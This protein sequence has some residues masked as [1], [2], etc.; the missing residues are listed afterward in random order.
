MPSP[1]FNTVIQGMMSYTA[2]R[3]DT[4]TLTGSGN[5]GLYNIF[6]DSLTTVSTRTPLYRTLKSWQLPDQ[7]YDKYRNTLSDPKFTFVAYSRAPGS[8]YQTKWTITSNVAYSGGRLTHDLASSADDPAQRAISKLIEEMSVTRSNISVGAAELGKTA[9]MVAKSAT[10]IFKAVKALKNARFG[11]FAGV[12]GLTTT[13]SQSRRFYTGLNRAVRRDFRGN[14]YGSSFQYD[15]AFR[16]YSRQ[17]GSR[18]SDFL[19]DTWLE[20]SYGWKPL[21]KDVHDVAESAANYL[22]QTQGEF[23]VAKTRVSAEKNTFTETIVSDTTL[24]FWGSS[25]IVLEMCVRYKIPP[26]AM[27][28]ANA[29][30]LNNPLEVAWELVPFSFIVDWFLPVGDA[31]RALTGFNGLVFKSGYKSFIHTRQIVSSAEGNGRTIIRGADTWTGANGKGTAHRAE[32]NF[33]RRIL[34]DFPNFGFPQFKDPRSFAHA[35]SAIALLQS[36]FLRDR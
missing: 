3:T 5:L 10:K 4:G 32:F 21:L 35:T 19:A 25:K 9:S 34:T 31:I 11:E 36:L 29:F 8:L 6:T 7:Y 28:F 15:R 26:G 20:Y 16:H 23:F 33:G 18:T 17:T 14:P 27:S 24:K 2:H 1:N 13:T 12:L 30:G 22:N